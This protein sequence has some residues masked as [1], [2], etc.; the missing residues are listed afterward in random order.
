[1]IFKN[2]L[3]KETAE[4]SDNTGLR[5]AKCPGCPALWKSQLQTKIASSSKQIDGVS[6]DK[7]TRKSSCAC[8]QGDEMFEL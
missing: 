8:D 5:S 6:L 1:M 7:E 2:W 4:D 3:S